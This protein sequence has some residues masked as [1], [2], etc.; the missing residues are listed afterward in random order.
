MH[1]SGVK[2]GKGKAEGPEPRATRKLDTPAKRQE[3]S[4]LPPQAACCTFPVSSCCTDAARAGCPAELLQSCRRKAALQLLPDLRPCSCTGSCG[5][6]QLHARAALLL[7]AWGWQ[8]AAEREQHNTSFLKRSGV[9]V[10]GA[11]AGSHRSL[12]RPPARAGQR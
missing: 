10:I 2:R 12:I 5:C 6:A 7:S 3:G 4:A 9:V 11:K 8:T 1:S